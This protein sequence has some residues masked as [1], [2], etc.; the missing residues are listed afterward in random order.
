MKPVSAHAKA[1]RF[2][3]IGVANA[4][5]DMAFYAIAL[6]WG[7]IPLMANFVG[8]LAAVTFSFAANSKL[9]F[10]RVEGRSR[11]SAYLRFAGSGALVTLGI[12]SL[13]V[14]Y[15]TSFLG[16]WGAKIAGIILAA[17]ANFFAARWSIESRH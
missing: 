10:T 13:V 8:W 4:L 1:L 7:L 15:G 16:V 5:V 12:T 6:K 17:I 3:M 2:G 14:W 9:T 11:L